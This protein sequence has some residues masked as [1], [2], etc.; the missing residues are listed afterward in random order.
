MGGIKKVPS[1]MRRSSSTLEA[2]AGQFNSSQ[3][4]ILRIWLFSVVLALVWMSTTLSSPATVHEHAKNHD[5]DFGWLPQ[6]LAENYDDA[7]FVRT[8]DATSE[9]LLSETPV[10]H[11]EFKR[12]P[13]PELHHLNLNSTLLK[14]S[15]ASSGN[16][17]DCPTELH[18]VTLVPLKITE[19][20]FLHVGKAGGG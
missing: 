1:A 19:F 10:N 17:S 3:K 16:S 9:P 12:K 7:P 4:L 2:G 14:R 11:P 5:Y 8:F 20:R 18:N 15:R 6:Q 13:R